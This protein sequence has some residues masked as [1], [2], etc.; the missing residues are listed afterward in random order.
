MAMQDGAGETAQRLMLDIAGTKLAVTRRG[1]GPALVCLHAIGHGARDFDELAERLGGHLSII[2]IDFPGHGDSPAE[3]APPA[4][5]RYAELVAGVVDALGLKSFA[6]LGNSIGG[7]TALR[8]AAAN[9]GRVGALIL[10]NSGGL[11]KVGLLARL[12][13]GHMARFFDSGARGDKS[14]ARKYRRYYERTVLTGPKSKARR[15]EIIA[16]AYKCAPLLAAAWREFGLP[17]ADIRHLP[18]QI[19]CPVLYA[20][21]KNDAAIAWSRSRRAAQTA[22]NYTVAMF[23]AGHSAFLEQPE[24]FDAALVQF[25]EKQRVTA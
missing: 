19:K 10:C 16:D 3:A 25:L 5:R 8:Y 1:R 24:A 4:P 7:A 20:W 23:D 13:T 6:L 2:A 11:Q 14:F 15:E 22:P 9:P 12:Y 21:A 17:D 18:R